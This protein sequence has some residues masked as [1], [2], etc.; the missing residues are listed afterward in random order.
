MKTD[1]VDTCWQFLIP[2]CLPDFNWHS[3]NGLGD[4]AQL[5][6]IFTLVQ[7]FLSL[8]IYGAIGS[9]SSANFFMASHV[10]N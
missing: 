4:T 2:Y 10:G 9:L 3:E 7:L 8:W 6:V 5:V 1:I